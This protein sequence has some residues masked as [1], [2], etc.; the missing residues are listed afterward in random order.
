MTATNKS[1][2]AM[3]LGTFGLGMS[4]FVVMGILPFMAEDFHISIPE[5]GY[6]ISAYAIG[7]CVGAPLVAIY[8]RRWPLKRLLTLLV[9]IMIFAATA[10]TL[11]PTPDAGQGKGWHFW[12]M[13][14]F[15]FI[16]GTPHGAYFGVGAIVADRICREG[17][18]AF[19]VSIICS[20]MTV[21]NLVG[22]PLGTLLTGLY[23]WRLVFAMAGLVDVAAILAILR[24]VPALAPSPDKGLRNAFRFLK[25]LAP[26]LLIGATL[27][28]NGGVFAWYSYISPT[29][30]QLAGV[31]IS[32]LTLMMVL[33][34]GGMVIG[35]LMG[36]RLSDRFGPGHT[37]RGIEIGIFSCL[38]LIALTA[39]LSW[40]LI[41][42]MF[43]ACGCLFAVSSPQ[44]LLLLR[45]SKGGELM[46]GAM[47]Q[48]AF[49]SGN[50]IGAWLGGL[51][52]VENDPNTYHYPAA[53]GA[54]LAAVGIICYVVFC[55]RY[56]NRKMKN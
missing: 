39:H 35:N 38:V 21:A 32:W 9:G 22:I 40:C 17:K 37:G 53:I 19:A 30:T 46:G 26:W 1:L 55:H 34:G 15:R 16:A 43:L 3:A 51:P 42:L 14:L 31:P 28:G 41:P 33:S 4:E 56:E 2:L 5:A 54:C 12:L 45:F 49:N 11:C 7:V 20:G 50:A 48:I 24:W 6:F 36:G 47:V 25:S 27:M 8:L 44:Q 10:M 29:L 23:S 18:A 52:I 13:I